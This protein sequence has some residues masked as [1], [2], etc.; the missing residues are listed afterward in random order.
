MVSKRVIAV[1]RDPSKIVK[2]CNN[3]AVYGVKNRIEFIV[4][5]FFESSGSLQA[6][7]VFMSSPWGGP[8]YM[9]QRV[10]DFRIMPVFIYLTV[11]CALKTIENVGIFFPRN[12]N[13]RQIEKLAF[14]S[15]YEI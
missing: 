11:K 13:R 15:R 8:E 10:I 6:H 1:G 9:K 12:L 5:D 3:A 4:G 14:G 7:V 2:T